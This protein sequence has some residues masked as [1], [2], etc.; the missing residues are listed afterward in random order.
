MDPTGSQ[1]FTR[2]A[3]GAW[4]E[5]LSMLRPEPGSVKN[6]EVHRGSEPKPGPKSGSMRGH[7][8][9]T[10][11]GL[12]GTHRYARVQ[13]CVINQ[14]SDKICFKNFRWLE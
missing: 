14:P 8:A 9:E 11:V 1:I 7:A 12:A 4:V 6:T 2:A 3:A 13:A 10:L 5:N